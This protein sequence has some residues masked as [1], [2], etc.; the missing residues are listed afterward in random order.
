MSET[1]QPELEGTR[2]GTRINPVVFYGSSAC[3]LLIALWAII[4]PA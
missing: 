3:I 1:R 4:S 2:P